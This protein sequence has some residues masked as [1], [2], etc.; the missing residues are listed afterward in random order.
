VDAE[1]LG[2]GI[3]SGFRCFVAAAIELIAALETDS[4][5]HDLTSIKEMN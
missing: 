4:A 1:K 5:G 2:G 3:A